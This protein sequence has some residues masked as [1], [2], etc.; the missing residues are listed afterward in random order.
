MVQVVTT[1]SETIDPAAEVVICSYT[2]AT[3]PT[4]L[5]QLRAR[6][7]N[8]L[9]LDEVQN[10]KEPSTKRT[11]AVY[12]RPIGT[13]GLISCADRVWA[14]SGTIAPNSVAEL[15]THARAFG[16]T[17]LTAPGWIHHFTITRE[18]PWGPKPVANRREHLPELRALW[19]PV[20]LRRK[21][22][23]VLADFP[24]IRTPTVA[25]EADAGALLALE[26]DPA[27]EP[28]R[29][30]LESGDDSAILGALERASGDAVSRLRRLTGL[31]KL[32]G[33]VALLKD[34][35]E[36]DPAHK[37][38]VFAH[39]RA[40]VRGLVTGL[41]EYGAVVLAGATRPADRQA[42]IDRFASDPQCRCFIANLVAGGTGISLVAAAHVVLVEASWVPSENSQAIARC[43][44]LG[45]ERGSVL[46]RFLMIPGS[47]DAAPSPACCRAR[48]R[49]SPSSRP[50]H[51]QPHPARRRAPPQHSRLAEWLHPRRGV[52]DVGRADPHQSCCRAP[53]ARRRPRR[54]LRHRVP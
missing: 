14:L 34:E 1:T 39:H 20:Y 7:W 38:V 13:G 6:R 54:H 23:Q 4:V 3:A 15:W 52:H 11:R 22:E 36:A 8:V 35:L 44:R 12:G 9:V 21:A 18:T 30:A 53:S 10:L 29:R 19:R 46:A 17:A 45:Q 16:L 31:A 50:R 33:A 2:T 48:W 28:L 24:S 25:V 47:L 5:R 51:E 32:P 27:L 41:S 49:C 40:V 42:A 37:V 26:A 43:R